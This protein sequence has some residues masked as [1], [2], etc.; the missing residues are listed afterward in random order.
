MQARQIAVPT[1][2]IHGRDDPAVPIEA[3][4]NLAALIPNAR[5]E[6]VE[7]EHVAGTGGTPEVRARILGFFD[8]EPSR[9]TAASPSSPAP[10]DARASGSG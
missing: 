9:P 4:R 5:F 1:L 3:G 2:V 6:I 8:E 10:P 7:G